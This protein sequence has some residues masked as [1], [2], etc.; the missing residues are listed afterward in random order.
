MAMDRSDDFKAHFL[1]VHFFNP[2]GK[3]LANELIFHPDNSESF[4]DAIYEFCE[5]VLRRVNIVAFNSP[6]FAANRIGFQFLNEAARYA[7]KYGVE[8]I[9]Y[10]LGPFTGRAL[11]PLATIDHV[12]I[13]V[14]KAIVDNIYSGCEDERHDTFLLSDYIEK[15]IE[16]EMLGLKSGP[17]GGFYRYSKEKEKFVIIP[18][19]LEYKKIENL[20]IDIV[21]IIKQALHDGNYREAI[22]I[23]RS[24]PSEEISLIRHFIL[25][26]ISYSY[27]RIGEVTSKDDGI[28]GIDRVMSYGFSW[29]PPSAW[30]DFFGGP[31]ETLKLM[32]C[33]DVPLPDQLKEAPE[34]K[35]CRIPEVTKYFIA[36]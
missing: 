35:Q 30:V 36:R 10:L 18:Q 17:A 6:G 20:K 16:N 13:D 7:E 8:Y 23:I 5:K 14:H 24:A 21:E 33:I 11:P 22:R 32:E 9:D 29:F 12:G 4:R 34:E 26:Y 31:G 28:H 27:S 25:G 19:T 3:L 2:P 1:G 15:M